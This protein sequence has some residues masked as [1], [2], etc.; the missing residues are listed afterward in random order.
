MGTLKKSFYCS[1]YIGAV[2]LFLAFVFTTYQKMH[3]WSGCLL[4][5]V[6]LNLAIALR[7][8]KMIFGTMMNVTG[9]SLATWWHNRPPK[10][11]SAER[12]DVLAN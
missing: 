10:D 1:Y 12:K 3:N 6:F 8:S 5:L 2:I 4:A 11:E 7:S 9:S